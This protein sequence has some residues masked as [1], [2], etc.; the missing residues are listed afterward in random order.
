MYKKKGR[1]SHRY[2]SFGLLNP[3]AS[4]HALTEGAEAESLKQDYRARVHYN[5]IAG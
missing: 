4:G 3:I 5:K 2:Y 1:V